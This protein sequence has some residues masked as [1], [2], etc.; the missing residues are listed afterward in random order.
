MPSENYV[1][2]EPQKLEPGVVLTIMGNDVY[3]TQDGL[4]RVNGKDGLTFSQATE[5]VLRMKPAPKMYL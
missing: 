1:R 2:G 5:E 4:F 3:R